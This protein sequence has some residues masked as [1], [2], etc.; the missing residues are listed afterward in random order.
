MR[1]TVYKNCQASVKSVRVHSLPSV[2]S[3]FRLACCHS[4]G[5]K[6]LE[7]ENPSRV[8]LRTSQKLLFVETKLNMFYAFS[9]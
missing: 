5:N 6:P 3:E 1:N 8:L 7:L 4:E 2:R 9:I